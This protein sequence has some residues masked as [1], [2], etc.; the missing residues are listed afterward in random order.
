VALPFMD[1]SWPSYY[2]ISPLV[3]AHD[4]HQL[5]VLMFFFFKFLLSLV[6]SVHSFVEKSKEEKKASSQKSITSK[7]TIKNH[8]WRGA[9]EQQEHT[10]WKKRP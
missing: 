5:F 3:S 8:G 2:F 1:A 4:S 9:N 7:R 6:L 10:K